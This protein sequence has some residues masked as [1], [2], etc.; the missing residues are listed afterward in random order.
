MTFR[1]LGNPCHL[2]VEPSLDLSPSFDHGFRFLKHPRICRDAKK[3]Q[4]AM[5]RQS[6]RS[7]AIELC[8][9]P[10]ARVF[11]LGKRTDVRVDEQIGVN[12]NHLY[13]SPSATARPSA[14]LSTLPARQVP[15]S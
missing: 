12:E 4:Q 11:M 5:P 9:K 7:I 3:R 13:D 14:P 6:N 15:G 10:P 1:R 2:A 8:V